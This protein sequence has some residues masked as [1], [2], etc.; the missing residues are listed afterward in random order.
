M[1]TITIKLYKLE[2]LSN[3]AQDHAHS[4]WLQGFDNPWASEN[5]DTLEAFAELFPVKI[6]SWSYGSTSGGDNVS[7]D[8]TCDD[9]IAEM[10]SLRLA[11]YIWNNYGDK[12]FKPKFIYGGTVSAEMKSYRSK[13]QR[14]ASCVLTGYCMDE[15]ILE[16]IYDFLKKPST[17][18]FKELIEDCFYQWVKACADD[19]EYQ[20]SFEAFRESCEANEYL[21]EEDGTLR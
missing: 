17:L 7:F 12:L 11:K 9:A 10:S 3:K 20:A 5:E 1:Q 15:T 2:E 4:E 6:K 14:E 16:P 13:V 8:M 21:F 18:T 19:L